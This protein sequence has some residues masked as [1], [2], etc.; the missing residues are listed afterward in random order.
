MEIL[1]QNEHSPVLVENQAAIIY[2]GTNGLLKN[3]PINKVKDF[4]KD[5]IDI[6]NLN[7]KDI[8]DRLAKG[9]LS[10]DITDILTKN[11][12]EVAQKYKK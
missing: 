6:L 3:V 9:E 7:H 12:N 2:C 11:A 5:F 1:K 8:M 4:E 10:D